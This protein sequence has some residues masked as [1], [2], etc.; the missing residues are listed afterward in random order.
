MA[1]EKPVVDE[2]TATLIEEALISIESASAG[3]EAEIARKGDTPGL[4]EVSRRLALAKDA[5]T[6]LSDFIKP[7]AAAND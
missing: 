5:L 1:D 2:I 7:E 4:A 3:F 6:D